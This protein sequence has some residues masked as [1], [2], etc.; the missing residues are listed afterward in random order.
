MQPLAVLGTGHAHQHLVAG[1]PLRLVPGRSVG[2]VHGAPVGVGANPTGWP[3]V[4]MLPGQGHLAAILQ[5]QRH[6]PLLQVEGDDGGK[7]TA[8][9]VTGHCQPGRIH[10]TLAPD[11]RHPLGRGIGVVDGGWIGVLQAAPVV[12][13][14]HDCLR[15]TGQAAAEMVVSVE[16]VDGPAAAVEV[17]RHRQ[18]AVR[19]R[20]VPAQRNAAQRPGDEIVLDLGDLDAGRVD[21]QLA[22]PGSPGIGYRQGE[23]RRQ[24]GGLHRLQER[25]GLR[26]ESCLCHV[27]PAFAGPAGSG[28]A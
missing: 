9:T 24:I 15:S 11:S 8:R 21:H 16:V 19:A 5:P 27:A 7:V 1:D 23:D 2:Q 17:Q 25:P 22:S 20:P 10:A 28:G 3:L 4:Q 18:P 26:I 6:R 12:H 14:D 13:R